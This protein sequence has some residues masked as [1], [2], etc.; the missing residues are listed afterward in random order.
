[1]EYP[2]HLN[3]MWWR[4]CCCDD[5]GDVVKNSDV[6]AEE[7]GQWVLQFYFKVEVEGGDSNKGGWI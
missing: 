7:G 6:V 2:K 4:C 3:L 5:D 1:M